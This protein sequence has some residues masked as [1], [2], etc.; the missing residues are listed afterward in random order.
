MPLNTPVIPFTK[1]H[2]LGNDFVVIDGRDLPD[3]KDLP[4]LAARLCDR[5]FGIGADGLITT[6]PPSDPD[7]F[8]IRFVYLNGDGSWAEMCGNGIRCFARFVRQRGLVDQDSFRVETLAGLITPTLNPDGTVTV[9]MGQ[10]VIERVNDAIEVLGRSIP[11]TTVS[12]GNPH[13]LVFQDELDTPLDPAVFGP[14]MEVHPAFPNKTNVEFVTVNRADDISVTVWERGCGFT[15]ACG[16]GACATAVGAAHRGRT[17]ST[18]T[19]HLPGGPLRIQ[20]DPSP[21]GHVR[22]TGPAVTV[23][24]GR[25][26]LNQA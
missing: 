24:E 10:P 5:H 7:R 25:A 3:S 16:T 8:D 6:A 1:M 4:A 20:W 22:M 2:G 17:G 15:L 12:M 11:I 26:A 23:F 19:V 21:E 9:D 13:C 18:A 14:A